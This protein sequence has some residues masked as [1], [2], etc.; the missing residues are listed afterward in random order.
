MACQIVVCVGQNSRNPKA[1]VLEVLF[2]LIFVKP[3]LEVLRIARRDRQKWYQRVRP[4]DE[5]VQS[6]LC[7]V[8]A[9][10]A[11]AAFLQFLMLH[12]RHPTVFM[13]LSIVISIAT[14][15]FTLASVD[16]NVDTD[17][18]DR[19][20]IPQFYGLIPERTGT[21]AA[22]FLA[23]GVHSFAQVAAAALG[24]ASLAHI[25]PWIAVCTWGG[26][27]A[28]MYAL[29]TA[30]RDLSWFYP[31]C[32]LWG[33]LLALAARS[34][35][36]IVSDLG[37]LYF[38]HPDNMGCVQWWFGQ[39][40][41]WMLLAT[42]IGLRATTPAELGLSAAL[43]TTLNATALGSASDAALS[44]T[45]NTTALD[46]GVEPSPLTDPTVLSITAALLFV[47]WL[48]SL[49]AFFLLA[50]RDYWHTFFTAETSAQYTKRVRWDGQ[51]G[52]EERAM[53]LVSVHPS[54]LRLVAADAAEWLEDNWDTW[55]REDTPADWLTDE[56]KRALPDSVISQKT[57]QALGGKTRRRTTLAMRLRL[58][59]GLLVHVP[60]EG[61]TGAAPHCQ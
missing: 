27:L 12:S 22:I 40:W 3:L 34:I 16:F 51:A 26:K 48:L 58:G 36:M 60:V 61:A 39:M 25:H 15:A 56:W 41:P 11:P 21:R 8:F 53:L 35:E 10:S 52:V 19:T 43:N 23:M 30:Q 28:A 32:G 2:A 33:I 5:N 18:T 42:A 7:A 46:G 17:P 9:E 37:L 50:N 55:T 29:K 6:K 44:T 14:V 31:V 49:A 38:R 4:A 54:L 1:T 45:L 24:T 47:M 20:N 57:L 13:Y 59:S